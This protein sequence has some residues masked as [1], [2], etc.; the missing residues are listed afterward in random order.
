AEIKD[1]MVVVSVKDNGVGMSNIDKNKLFKKNII[2]TTQG[3]D[4][5]KGTG[6]GL[7]LTKEMVE[8]NGGQIWFESELGKG[9]TFFVS[10]PAE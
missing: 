6:L 7:L 8:K 10:F 5:E 9:T 1:N 2:H 3:T 4:D